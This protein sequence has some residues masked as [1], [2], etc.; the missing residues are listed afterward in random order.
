MSEVA[1][2]FAALA[3]PTRRGVVELLREGDRRAGELAAALETSRPA[4]SRHLK[5][6]RRSGLIEEVRDDDPADARVRVF[7]LRREPFDGMQRWLD[8]VQAYWT[9]QLDAFREHVERRSG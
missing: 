1:A 6:L 2:T 8:E 7:R 5:V 9:D 3:D 4:M